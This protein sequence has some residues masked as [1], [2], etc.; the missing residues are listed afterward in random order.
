M[1]ADDDV[2]LWI[3]NAG[4]VWNARDY[5][6]WLSRLNAEDLRVTDSEGPPG[7]ATSGETNGGV[8]RPGD[9]TVLEDSPASW[10]VIV[11]TGAAIVGGTESAHQGDYCFYNESAETLTCSPA[12]GSLDR[13]DIVGIRVRDEEESGTDNDAFLV[14]VEGTAHATPADPTLPDNFLSLARIV[15]AGGSSNIQ[16]SDITDLRQQT[17]ALGG[18]IVREQA[19]RPTVGLWEGQYVHETD[20][21]RLIWYSGTGW[22][23]AVQL[24]TWW[25]WTPV[26]Y[27]T[28]ANLGNSTYTAR[29][30]MVGSTVHAVFT[31]AWGSTG[32]MA[33]DALRIS[34]P[35]EAADLN[36]QV[37][38]GGGFGVDDP[39]GTPRW[40]T[41]TPYIDSVNDT[42]NDR[43]RIMA[44]GDSLSASVGP[45]NTTTPF[46]WVQT[47]AIYVSLT[48][49][50]A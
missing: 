10:D 9:L 23:T 36:A 25:T 5:R 45:I 15:L 44:H 29:Y 18:I 38:V 50:A 2:A 41:M 14:V 43:F 46:P 17:A 49:E 26:L 48:Y 12:H 13:H 3:E 24:G 40:Y 47:D 7:L 34:L 8:M 33:T 37:I 32:V 31:M 19:T 30:M 27:G 21:D 39:G 1:A 4:T 16:Q 6:R 11:G 20:N 35:V 22:Q 42:T 28:N